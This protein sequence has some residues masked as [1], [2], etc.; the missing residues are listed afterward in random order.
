MGPKLSP[1]GKKAREELKK[2]G[3]KQDRRKTGLG[4][5]RSLGVGGSK[6]KKS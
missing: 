3:V 4:Y 6:K 2:M 1:L 5:I